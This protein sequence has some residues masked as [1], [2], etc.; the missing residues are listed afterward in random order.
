M[1]G[2]EFK[3]SIWEKGRRINREKLLITLLWKIDDHAI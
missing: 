3:K 2:T 1:I